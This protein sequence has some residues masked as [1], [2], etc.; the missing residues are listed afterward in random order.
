ML[1]KELEQEEL[2][3]EE[4]EEQDE[5]NGDNEEENQKYLPAED[6]LKQDNTNTNNK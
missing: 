2:E 4:D 1:Y 5:N 6:N 3:G